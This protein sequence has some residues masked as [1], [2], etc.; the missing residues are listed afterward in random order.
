MLKRSEINIYD[1]FF[2]VGGDSLLATQLTIGIES[3]H[4]V[5]MSPQQISFAPTIAGLAEILLENQTEQMYI[6]PR[7]DLQ[8]LALSFAQQQLWL[9]QEDLHNCIDRQYL[10]ARLTGDLNPIALQ[11]A[12]DTIV[13]R[14]EVLRTNII[15]TGKDA[16]PVVRSPRTVEL[17]AIDLQ[18]DLQPQSDLEIERRLQQE[19]LRTFDLERDL[20]IRGCWLRVGSQEHILLLTIH[21]IA[22]DRR[23]LG[24]LATQLQASY[25]GYCDASRVD[26]APKLPEI[27]IQ[28]ADFAI[29][30]QQSLQSDAIAVDRQYW[31]QQLAGAPVLLDLPTDRTRPSVQTRCGGSRS[32][33]IDR[34]LTAALRQLSQQSGVKLYVA[35]LAAFETLLYR[36]TGSED[37]VVGVPIDNRRPELADSIGLFANTLVLRTDLSGNPSWV[38]LLARLQRVVAGAQSHQDFPFELLVRELYPQSDLSH[39][40]VFQVMFEFEEDRLAPKIE[41]ANLVATPYAIDLHTAQYDLTLALDQT[42]EGL[43]GRWIYNTD[44]FDPSTID[45][46]VEHFQ[47]L[48]EG[49]V[50]DS[51]QS[52]GR[53]P[54]LPASE[55]HQLVVT[56]NDTHTVYPQDRCIHQLFEQQVMLTPDAVAIIFEQQQL[57][58]QELNSRSNQLARH[59]RSLGVQAGVLV[60]ICVERSLEMFVGLLGILKAGGA[61]V[62]LDPVYPQ[63]RL[64]YMLA[65]SQMPVLVTQTNL[66]SLLPTYSAQLVCLDRDWQDLASYEDRNL[67][68]SATATDL[69][70]IIYTSG[71]TGK[72]KGVQIRHG[73][74]TNLLTAM[75]TTPGMTAADKFLCI[76]TISFDMAVPELYLPLSVGAKIVLVSREVAADGTRLL[77][78]IDRLKPTTIQAT[79]ATWQMLLAVGWTNSLPL[80]ILCG[81]EALSPKLAE[82]LLARAT[83]VWNMYGPTE[84]TV[85]ATAYDVNQTQVSIDDRVS[86]ISIGKPLGNVRVYIL[87]AHL[88]PVPIGISGELYIG[89]VC[90]AQGYLNRPELTAQKFIAN[91]FLDSSTVGV[92]DSQ[93][94]D[95]LYKTGDLARYL[96]DGNIDYFGRIDNQVK[97]RGFRI[98]LGEIETLLAQHPAIDQVTVIVREDNPGDRRLVA[99]CVANCDAPPK[100]DRL[101]EF[102]AQKVPNYMVPAMFSIQSALPMTPNGKVDRR[103]LP[104]P[105]YTRAD[106]VATFVAPQDEIEIKLTE[107]WQRIL[108]SNSI[109]IKD[110]FFDLGGHSLLAVSLFNEIEKIWGQSLP[111][112]T[113]FQLQTI[114][115]L[116]DLLRQDGYTASW[117]SLVLIQAGTT[118]QPPLFCIHPV[119]GNT[120]EYYQLANYLGTDRAIY[121]LQSQ[122]LNGLQQPLTQIEQ[123]ASQ[124]IQEMLAVQ[125][126]GPYLLLGYSFGGFIAFEIAQQLQTSGKEVAFLALLDCIAPTI[127]HLRPSFVKSIQIHLN[128]LWQLKTKERLKYI[129]DRIDYRLNNVDYKEF[130]IRG[131]SEVAPPSPQLLNLID[132]NLQAERE[133]IARPYSG[134]VNIFRCQV[135]SLSH[136]LYPDLG[137]RELVSGRLEVYNI[138]SAHYGFLRDPSVQIV[139]EKLNACL[140]KLSPET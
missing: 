30:Q 70:Y 4:K 75:Q 86:S 34:E 11:Q 92:S 29:W 124:Y 66:V 40:P 93:T 110:N 32:F 99:Y 80:K 38:E 39:T 67:D 76:T 126:D 55:Y 33:K 108:G 122:G 12:L 64:A 59:L 134:D 45:R 69:A 22:A 23:S 132:V 135:Q 88:Q 18:S 133:Y 7:N 48:L 14:H 56:W 35:L 6:S 13:E 104:V 53:L 36:Y 115:K 60:G 109:G 84:A 105:D 68:H 103:A 63:D 58:Y 97:L 50:A 25:A 137:W 131:L 85:W 77:Q 28:S 128:N 90:L 118:A 96:P 101:R 24:I 47:T 46:L 129:R 94:F 107:I 102:I 17:L 98:E 119:G 91:P 112:A 83:S 130:V 87:D 136:S 61:Y 72:P 117:S 125:P 127:G 62:P 1:N 15:G 20:M 51:K 42:A 123:M 5:K 139:A 8:S 16:V 74:V 26:L 114:E 79:P 27:K 73:G 19:Y 2:E 49:I 44:L 31:Q 43:V 9:Q 78:S 3:T 82:R 41:L 81:G 121:G 111:L 113:L 21:A 89:G 52:I 100:I 71:S 95:R 106:F 57:T 120:L 140:D 65:D 138:P 37:L 116:A 54:L 10:A